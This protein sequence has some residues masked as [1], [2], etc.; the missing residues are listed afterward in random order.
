MHEKDISYKNILS[1]I[2]DI[3]NE[4]EDAEQSISD[5][6]SNVDNAKE[7]L[8]KI[9]SLIKVR[10]DYVTSENHRNSLALES[11][12]HLRKEAQRIEENLLKDS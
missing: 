4:L 6:Q 5:A 8:M 1:L 11:I 7:T 10:Q 3:T 2:D 9:R 12:K